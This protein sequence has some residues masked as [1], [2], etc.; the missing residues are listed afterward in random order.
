M[1]DH[2]YEVSVRWTG[3]RGTGTSGYRDYGRDHDVT[4]PGKHAISG[5]ADPAFRG[6]RDRWNPEE[7]LLGALAQC[8]MMSYL[9]VAVQQGFTVLDYTD[10]ATASLDVTAER[11]ITNALRERAATTTLVIIA[12]RRSALAICDRI[13]DL[14]DGRF[15]SSDAECA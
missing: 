15:T 4:A 10:T 3:D 6:D 8:H 9:Y 14:R 5:S 1:T 13:F 2:T 11:E 7:M 12:H